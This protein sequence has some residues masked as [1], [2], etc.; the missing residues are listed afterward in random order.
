MQMFTFALSGDCANI[1][2][3]PALA[4]LAGKLGPTAFGK[5]ATEIRVFLM[6]MMQ[7]SL[8]LRALI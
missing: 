4:V 7:L 2:F 1:C 6:E 8:I 3:E 5:R